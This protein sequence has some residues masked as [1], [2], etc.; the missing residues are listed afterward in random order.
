MLR[1]VG[2]VVV[3]VVL[4]ALGGRVE[5]PMGPVPFILTDFFVFLG[6][7]LLSPRF[8]AISTVLFLVLGALGLPV[9]AEG[10]AGY[11]HLVGPTSGY[12]FGYLLGGIM[13][14]YAKE[15]FQSF[16]PRLLSSFLGYYLLFVLGVSS[17]VGLGGMSATEAFEAGALPFVF[18]MHIKA[19]L[20]TAIAHICKPLLGPEGIWA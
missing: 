12:L 15:R 6:A 20:A 17:L 14:S 5:I 8:F 2:S 19:L 9:Y 10:S 18:A 1:K 7:L 11:E 3:L 4:M 13:V 16:L